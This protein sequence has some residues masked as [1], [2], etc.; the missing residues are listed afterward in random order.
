MNTSLIY[1]L[2][3][4]TVCTALFSTPLARF[5]PPALFPAYISAPRAAT[6]IYAQLSETDMGKN[7][8]YAVRRGKTP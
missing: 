1:R 5:L 4:R 7:A 8:F 6:P 2:G 3:T